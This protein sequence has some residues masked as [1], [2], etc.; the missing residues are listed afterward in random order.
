MTFFLSILTILKKD[1]LM[2]LRTKEMLT[3]MFIFAVLVI[4]IFNFAFEASRDEVLLIGP[5]ILWVAFC[6]AGTL[7]LNH[8]AAMEKENGCLQGMMLTP[9]DRGTIYLGKTA[10]NALFMFIV[11]LIILPV[12]ALLFNISLLNILPQL[13]AVNVVGTIG[14]SG[15]GTIIA[16]I[17]ANTKMREV[18]LPI[19]LFPILLPLLIGVIESTAILLQGG[20]M[21]GYYNWLKIVTVFD[22]V[23]IV[24]SYW[25]FDYVLEE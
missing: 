15:V 1:L 6:F 14:F 21:G 2:E 11:E 20:N 19:V 18:L 16:A 10:A 5:G 8:S 13:L 7:G 23:F 24:V 9:I 22:V 17:T 12:F 4:V 3:S 25:V